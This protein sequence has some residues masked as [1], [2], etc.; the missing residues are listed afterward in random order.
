MYK[1]EIALKKVGTMENIADALT[2]AV[3]RETLDYHVAHAAAE[4]RRDRLRLVPEVVG[5]DA[6]EEGREEDCSEQEL[7]LE[8]R[9]AEE[10]L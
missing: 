3:N 5:E 7:R 10:S 1:G 2:N 9:A 6:E 8:S 4:C